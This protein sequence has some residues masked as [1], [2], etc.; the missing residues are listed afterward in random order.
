VVHSYDER[1]RAIS[2]DRHASLPA[3]DIDESPQVLGQLFTIIDRF[4]ND[5][6]AEAQKIVVLYHHQHLKQK[7]VAAL[8][9]QDRFALVKSKDGEISRSWAELS[10]VLVPKQIN[11]LVLMQLPTTI[12]REQSNF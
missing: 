5:L 3:T 8:I 7:D 11:K 1:S 10:P 6:P 12:I 2:I 9:A 4:I